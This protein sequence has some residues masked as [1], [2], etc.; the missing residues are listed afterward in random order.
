MNVRPVERSET[1]PCFGIGRINWNPKGDGR[2]SLSAIAADLMVQLGEFTKSR[3]T[4][5]GFTPDGAL[6]VDHG[7]LVLE[8][9]QTTATT[10]IG[11]HFGARDLRRGV[12]RHGLDAD[13]WREAPMQWNSA[14]IWLANAEG[15]LALL[16]GLGRLLE[17]MDVR[18]VYGYPDSLFGAEK[19]KLN[20][21]K[22]ACFQLSSCAGEPKGFNP[23][24]V[25]L[26]CAKVLHRWAHFA[27][28]D[29]GVRF[30][31]PSE[32]TWIDHVAMVIEVSQ[33]GRRESVG[34]QFGASLDNGEVYRKALD[35]ASWENSPAEWRSSGL[36]FLN[37][38]EAWAFLC[39][40]GKRLNVR[41][42]RMCYGEGEAIY[43]TRMSEGLDAK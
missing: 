29:M 10:R 11:F 9:T 38:A 26:A 13:A 7:A 19:A 6:G 23:S 17:V 4:V 35:A 28:A 20:T 40:I 14:G 2:K 33:G 8:L 16:C 12:I 34:A 22:A 43:L 18:F 3:L 21:A 24:F 37:W 25:G 36:Y 42:A 31:T 5:Y 39:A 1:A 41:S 30:F 32:A 27:G 15:A